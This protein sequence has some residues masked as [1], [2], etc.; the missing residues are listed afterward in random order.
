[1]MQFAGS[2][3]YNDMAYIVV[4]WPHHHPYVAYLL[5][6]AWFCLFLFI[7]EHTRKGVQKYNTITME[8]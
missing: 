8:G 3:I 6:V 5:N 7:V 4:V 1:M 2:A